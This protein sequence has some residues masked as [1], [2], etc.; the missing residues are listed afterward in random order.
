MADESL[1]PAYTPGAANENDGAPGIATALS[2]SADKTGV[3]KAIKFY[4]TA[5]DGGTYTVYLYRVTAG[6]ADPGPGAGTQL[7]TK[8]FAG[9][10][11][12]GWNTV[13]LDAPV[14]IDPYPALYK[15]VRHNSQGRYVALTNGLATSVVVGSLTAWGAADS[16]EFPTLGTVRNGTYGAAAAGT[17]PASFSGAP[18]YGVDVVF[19]ATVEASEGTADLGLVYTV[20]ATGSAPAVPPAEGAVALGI[21]ITGTAVGETPDPGEASGATALG[22]VYTL[23]VT[24][25][26]PDPASGDG[27]A[28]AGWLRALSGEAVSVVAGGVW[29]M[30]ADVR[31]A[32]GDLYVDDP[33]LTI[34]LPDGTTDDIEVAAADAYAL[35][36][37]YVARYIPP[38][39]GRYVAELETL[40]SGTIYFTALVYPAPTEDGMPNVTD[41][42]GT[43][44][45]DDLG[46][47]GSNSW[48][49]AE[50]LDALN[51]EMAAQMRVC[52]VP[53]AYPYDL[54]QALMRRVARNL[55][56]RRVPT[57][58]LRG[59][60]DA[61]PTYLP[62]R[63]PEVRRLESP[64]RKVV[65]A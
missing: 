13:T 64:W 38:A 45:G 15:A 8:V 42:V 54:R 16:G 35:P 39:P 33:V 10:A 18:N 25:E 52:R 4:R 26:A 47:L 9:S 2:F 56:L 59:D 34:T 63:D 7:A 43:R 23:A 31:D 37:S 61:G 57:A 20:S 41:L 17:Y 12:A 14:T 29:E 58:V 62:G 49:D 21:E 50:V 30:R 24:G 51:A 36:G 44:S 53:A 46:Y 28:A 5:T 22:L 60:A 19:E 40:T 3:I 11:V 6:E 65:I 1:F 55:A 32:Y 48:T 27:T